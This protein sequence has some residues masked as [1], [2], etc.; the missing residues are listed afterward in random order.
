[1]AEKNIFSIEFTF[2]GNKA[3]YVSFTSDQSL[4]DADIIVFNP[5]IPIGYDIDWNNSSY[6]GKTLYND[7]GS[8]KLKE[9]SSHWRRELLTAF[10]AGKTIFIFLNKLDE[11][12]I[13]TGQKQHSG[14]GRNTR[15]TNIVDNYDNYKCIPFNLGKIITAKGSKINPVADLKYLAH[16]WQEF[17]ENSNYEVYLDGEIGQPLLKTKTGNKTVARIIYGNKAVGEGN[18]FLLPKLSYNDKDFTEYKNEK[19]YWNK[20]GIIFGTK[21]ANC[22]IAID[23]ALHSETEKSVAPDWISDSIY[24]LEQESNYEKQIEEISQQIESL[25]KKTKRN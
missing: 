6:Q 22:F 9:N 14:T 19:S 1:M 10:N 13:Q 16:Y 15:I 18:I 24:K 7:S 3:E 12:F 11:I 4:L 8:F 2:P 21:L 17:K 23:K 20:E 5:T 25:E